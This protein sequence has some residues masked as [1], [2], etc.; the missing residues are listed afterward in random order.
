MLFSELK[1]KSAK[2][3]VIVFTVLYRRRVEKKKDFLLYKFSKSYYLPQKRSIYLAF[4]SLA[5]YPKYVGEA[6]IE[7]CAL[8]T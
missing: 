8:A 1:W 2:K 5:L 3:A 6:Q 7:S 4:G